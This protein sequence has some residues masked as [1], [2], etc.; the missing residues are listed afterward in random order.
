MLSKFLTKRKTL[1]FLMAFML[2]LFSFSKTALAFSGPTVRGGYHFNFEN[3]VY[4]TEEMNLQSFVNE[5]LKATVSSVITSV[6]GCFSCTPE[7]RE[8][9]P[10][11][12]LAAGHLMVGMYTSP[13]ASG[14]DYL[15]DM[16]QKLGVVKPAYAQEE[17]FGFNAM[18]RIRPIWTA[19]RNI[20]YVFFVLILVFIG[21]AIMFRVKINPQT[22]ISLQSALPKIVIALILIT[23]SYAIVGL[24]IDLMLVFSGLITN[25]FI[26]GEGVMRSISGVPEIMAE[27]S[28]FVG[29]LAPNNPV[30]AMNLANGLFFTLAVVVSLVA[31]IILGPISWLVAIIAIILILIAVL[32]CVWTMLKAYAMIIVSLIFAP[33]QILIGTLPGSDAISSWFRGLIGNIAVFPAMLAMFYIAAYLMLSGV[34]EIFTDPTKLIVSLVSGWIPGAAGILTPVLVLNSFEGF[35]NYI[36]FLLLPIIGLMILLM[37]PKVTDMINSF[38][39]GKPFEFGAAL[40]QAFGPASAAGRFGMRGAPPFLAERY[41]YGDEENK[42]KKWLARFGETAGI[43]RKPETNA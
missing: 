28:A 32:R 5:T 22:V 4:K 9:Y 1:L 29:R 14:V 8:K 21:F 6:V 19:F 18:A 23:F 10:G 41:L 16:G 37:A 26:G 24:M 38:L 42:M 7:E 13:P 25:L 2:L 30:I 31:A 36:S 43:W 3:A 34:A 12:L 39:A 33:L 15:A 11:F 20:S 27:I 35:W 17:G 40:G